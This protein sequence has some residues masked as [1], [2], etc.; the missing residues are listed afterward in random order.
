MEGAPARKAAEGGLGSGLSLHPHPSHKTPGAGPG[1]HGRDTPPP[2]RLPTPSF[3]LPRAGG[4]VSRGA[5]TRGVLG[6]VPRRRARSGR[7]V[8]GS[9]RS[10]RSTSA[11][12]G[13]DR[14]QRLPLVRQRSGQ[15]MAKSVRV[16]SM[17][18]AGP[19]GPL[20]GSSSRTAAR[21]RS[22]GRGTE[23]VGCLAQRDQ[24]PVLTGVSVVAEC[25]RMPLSY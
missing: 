13:R 14:R 6:R 22:L 11:Q 21:Q 10:P 8:V 7:S 23:I 15:R 5:A 2:L 4:V 12:A 3:P 17:F 19:G 1:R 20:T 18:D 25:Q 9:G 24:A 16:N